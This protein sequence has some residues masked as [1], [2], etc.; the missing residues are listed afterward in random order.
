MIPNVSEYIF[1]CICA[2]REEHF[3]SFLVH[4]CIAH[5][6][7]T[8]TVCMRAMMLFV[9]CLH[10]SGSSLDLRRLFNP[11]SFSP[12]APFKCLF[13]SVEEGRWLAM[14]FPPPPCG[15]FFFFPN[16]SL[17]CYFFDNIQRGQRSL[18]GND[19]SQPMTHQLS[20]C[21]QMP[22]REWFIDGVKPLLTRILGNGQVIT[23]FWLLFSFWFIVEIFSKIGGL[24]LALECKALTF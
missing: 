16:L 12:W 2:P 6:W 1:I 24:F 18:V 8:H 3:F 22:K 14:L 11:S 17:S 10:G 21:F 13:C 23:V 19:S 15:F 5:P 20:N 7:I 9:C 4:R